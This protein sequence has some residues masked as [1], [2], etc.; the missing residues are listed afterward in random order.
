MPEDITWC[1]GR[2]K[3]AERDLVAWFKRFRK[4]VG[5][6]RDNRI[7]LKGFAKLFNMGFPNSDVEALND[8]IREVYL[9]KLKAH[10]FTLDFKV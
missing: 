2:T 6:A 5:A 8:F 10:K 9:N 1:R 4:E 3:F 7:N